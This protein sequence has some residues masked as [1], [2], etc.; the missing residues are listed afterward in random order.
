MCKRTS[1]L[2]LCSC[3]DMSVKRI[4]LLY[5]EEI[6]LLDRKDIFKVVRWK[7]NKYISEEWSGMDGLMIMPSDNLTQELSQKYILKELNESNCFDFE[8][9]PNNGDNLIFEIGWLFNKWGKRIKTKMEYEYSS[10]IFENDKWE[11]N[12]YNPFYEKTEIIKEGIV[13]KAT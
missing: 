2:E 10:F 4:K 6:K 9:E 8:Y 1:K 13:K 7:L 11:I 12:S 3:A 5:S